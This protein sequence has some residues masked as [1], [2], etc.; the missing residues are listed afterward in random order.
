MPVF[1]L[2]RE[3]IRESNVRKCAAHVCIGNGG[4]TKEPVHPVRRG[5]CCVRIN[6]RS[7]TFFGH[8][9]SSKVCPF[10]LSP[11]SP[12]QLFTEAQLYCS[13]SLRSLISK[14]LV[15][16]LDRGRYWVL[17]NICRSDPDPEMKTFLVLLRRLPKY[18]ETTLY[19]ASKFI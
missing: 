7:Q 14:T 11:L 17:R 3:V 19:R 1:W 18:R 9:F 8:G 6:R 15:P 4:T 5:A 10:W 2:L 16:G 13:N 12:P